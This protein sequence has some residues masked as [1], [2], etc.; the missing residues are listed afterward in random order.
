ME[1]QKQS[2]LSYVKDIKRNTY[3]RF[4]SEE[5]IKIVLM[6]LRGEAKV[7]EICRQV[8]IAKSLYYKWTKNFMEAGKN[9]LQGDMLREATSSEVKQLKSENE[10]LKI[11]V[12]E[13][14]LENRILKKSLNGSM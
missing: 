10:E 5:K 9:R 13:Q 6:G 8:G 12:A 14:T 4:S 1:E 7:S 11:I 3:R 2:T